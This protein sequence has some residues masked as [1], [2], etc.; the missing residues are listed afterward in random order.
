MIHETAQIQE[1]DILRIDLL[2]LD[3]L[4][5]HGDDLKN[6]VLNIVVVIENSNSIELYHVRDT[7]IFI[8]NEEI[9][10]FLTILLLELIAIDIFLDP[11]LEID[12]TLKIIILHMVLDQDHVLDRRLHLDLLP[13]IYNQS[14]LK[15]M[16][17][18]LKAFQSQKAKVKLI[19]IPLKWQTLKL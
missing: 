11:T 15:F 16:A 1:L 3:H 10:G 18:T 13:I 2:V 6:L 12:S 7:L 19:C 4:Q 17:T 14:P 9:L 8:T 5:F